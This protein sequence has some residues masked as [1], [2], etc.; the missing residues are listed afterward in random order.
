MKPLRA[1]Y[2]CVVLA[3]P[4]CS[5]GDDQGAL[6]PQI[7][8]VRYATPEAIIE[9]FKTVAQD[10]GALA[11]LCYAESE[12]QGELIGMAALPPP[13]GPVTIR[14]ADG[15]RAVAGYKDE[16]T[17]SHDLHLVKIGDRWWVSGYTFEY[18]SV[19]MAN[20]RGQQSEP[21][22]RRLDFESGL[23][24]DWVQFGTSEYEITASS[25][26]ARG[27]ARC[28]QVRC[29]HRVTPREAFGALTFSTS[30]REHRGKRL[31]LSGFLR[32]ENARQGAGLWM[33]V[34]G[35]G[36]PP[37]TVL[38][39]DNMD[40]RRVRGTSDWREYA[41]VLDLPSTADAVVFGVLLN[42]SGTVW[43]DDLVLEEVGG[44]VPTTAMDISP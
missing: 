11:E 35:P 15:A 41:V 12:L 2:V 18:D 33:R 21:S 8:D 23:P 43:A 10:T 29:T 19:V 40:N 39:F 7:V 14:T 27:G 22:I 36:R 38:A 20:R 34:D 16:Q 25:D 32:T 44:N 37:R 26:S 28:A 4:G 30:A 24:R 5:G 3:V 1:V 13:A 42:G 6:P 17:R 31:R 9:E